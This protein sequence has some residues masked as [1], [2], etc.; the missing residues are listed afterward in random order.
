MFSTIL[1]S[2]LS[3]NISKDDSSD[4]HSSNNAVRP[5]GILSFVVIMVRELGIEYGSCPDIEDIET[6]G[7]NFPTSSY[8]Y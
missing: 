2:Q 7:T 3:F 5:E 8:I 4:G 6:L 1:D